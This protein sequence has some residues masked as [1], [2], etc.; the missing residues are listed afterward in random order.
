MMEKC[1]LCVNVSCV[2]F[3]LGHENKTEK[4]AL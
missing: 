3:W 2:C 1:N 4:V